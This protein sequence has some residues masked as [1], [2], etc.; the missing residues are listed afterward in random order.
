MQL[1]ESSCYTRFIETGAFPIPTSSYFL[2]IMLTTFNSF[3]SG[4]GKRPM[5]QILLT[6]SW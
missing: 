4:V 1:V 5:D 2:Y 3:N 6:L